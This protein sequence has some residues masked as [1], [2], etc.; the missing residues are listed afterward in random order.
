MDSRQSPNH[1]PQVDRAIRRALD[2]LASTQ[3][4]D[5][6]WDSDYSG[7]N[8]LLPML[9]SLHW[10]S[11]TSIPGPRR[12]AMARELLAAQ[13]PDGGLG[14]HVEGDSCQFSTSLGYVAL[15]LLGESPDRGELQRMRAWI[16]EHGTPLRSAPW[17]KWVLCPLGLYDYRGLLP[18]PPAAWLLPRWLPFHPG[19]LWCHNRMVYLPLAWMWGRRPQGVPEGQDADG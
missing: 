4:S 13:N 8:F 17:G 5:G 19:R 10:I 14:L 2:H 6:S 18:V 9:V 3:E 1:S 15:R 12:D 11:G 7:L 16:H